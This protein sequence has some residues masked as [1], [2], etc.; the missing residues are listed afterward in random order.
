LAPARPRAAAPLRR[1]VGGVRA[2]DRIGRPHL[3]RALA[4]AQAR[5]DLRAQRALGAPGDVAA[6]AVV[7]AVR[8]RSARRG[9]RAVK[10]VWI[11]GNQA[12][13]L[14]NGE[15]YFP[16][17]LEAIASARRQVLIETFILFEDKVG[18]ELHRVLVEIAR[19]GVQVDVTV[20]GYGSADLTPAFLSALTEVG[21]R[22][23]LFDPKPKIFGL[24]RN[25]FRRMHR[26]I[27]VVDGEVAFVGGINFS[28]DH[29]ADFGPMAKQDYAVEVR[30]PI[31][32]EI[33][34]FVV[35]MLPRERRRSLREM[36]GDWFER[37]ADRAA[38]EDARAGEAL[39]AFVIRDNGTHRNDIEH[40]Y[41]VAFR[42]ARSYVF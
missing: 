36:L 18:V 7:A 24:R 31:V 14:E 11:G 16:R 42:A 1:P 28:A 35:R 21:V 23:H 40:Q 9:V 13:L 33:H 32:D 6:A 15:E 20:D 8:P 2:G 39:A 34:R 5:S 22:V 26:K 41:R 19:R 12:R 38:R 3:S 25:L 4:G 29:L 17:V 10:A 37:R 30:G 27:V